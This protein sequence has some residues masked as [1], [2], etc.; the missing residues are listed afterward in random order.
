VINATS[1]PYPISLH[2]NCPFSVTEMALEQE[3]E[4]TD[5]STC[6]KDSI[7]DSKREPGPNVDLEASKERPDKTKYS[8]SD[9][10]V[11]ARIAPVLPRLRGYDFG[12]DDSGSDILGRQLELEAGN[13]IQYRTCSWQ[14]VC[15]TSCRTGPFLN[16]SSLSLPF[17]VSDSDFSVAF[18]F[19]ALCSP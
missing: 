7:L 13:A 1:C 3:Q 12:S 9:R 8:H 15:I 5:L 16:V 19:L 6:N 2:P 11:G 4:P 10:S 18:H 17:V 14:K